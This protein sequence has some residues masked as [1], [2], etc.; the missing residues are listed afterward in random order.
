[1]PSR[2]A[3]RFSH[4]DIAHP[5]TISQLS[6]KPTTARAAGHHAGA[7]LSRSELRGVTRYGRPKVALVC[8][9]LNQWQSHALFRAYMN[10]LY[11][12]RA[13]HIFV[14]HD[15]KRQRFAS[16]EDVS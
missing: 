3:R 13:I 11:C 16:G 4:Y 2:R 9:L 1:M 14:I 6:P 5:P 15:R 12:T 8:F 10:S 7:R